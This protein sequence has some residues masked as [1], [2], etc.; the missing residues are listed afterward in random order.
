MFE[1]HGVD[2][3]DRGGGDRAETHEGGREEKGNPYCRTGDGRGK[4]T[5]TGGD[6]SDQG[7]RAWYC[8]ECRGA[9][10]VGIAGDEGRGAGIHVRG[11]PR[12]EVRG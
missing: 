5:F 4:T 6:G 11:Y 2:L 8:H 9:L 7:N 1:G 10:F 12:G 3:R